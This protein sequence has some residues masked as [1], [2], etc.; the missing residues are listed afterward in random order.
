MLL[1]QI[2]RNDRPAGEVLTKSTLP[3]RL[4]LLCVGLDGDLDVRRDFA[5]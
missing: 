3:A 1:F 4:A 5:V 2:T